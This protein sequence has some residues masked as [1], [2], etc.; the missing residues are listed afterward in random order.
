MTAAQLHKYQAETH[1]A[2][3][4][5]RGGGVLG[6]IAKHAPGFEMVSALGRKVQ[7][8]MDTATD[9]ANKAS[10]GLSTAKNITGG[11]LDKA[12]KF[13]ADA[14]NDLKDK[15]SGAW[16]R[17]QEL[18]SA[19]WDKTKEITGQLWESTKSGVGAAVE[20]TKNNWQYL[21]A[22]AVLAGGLLLG[23][24][25]SAGIVIGFAVSGGVEF[26]SQAIA[27][28][29][30]LSKIDYKKVANAS[31]VG[32]LAGGAGAGVGG[33]ITKSIATPALETASA[34][35]A[36]QTAAK[37]TAGKL[38]SGMFDSAVSNGVNGAGMEIFENGFKDPAA[39]AR[40]GAAG[41]ATGVLTPVGAAGTR[42][43]LNKAFGVTSEEVIANRV[44]TTV[45]DSLSGGVFGAGNYAISEDQS[46][47]TWEG[48]RDEFFK[49]AAS[50]GLTSD[51]VKSPVFE[52]PLQSGAQA[53]SPSQRD[54]I[55]GA[56][57]VAVSAN[58][59]AAEELSDDQQK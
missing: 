33:L 7:G 44:T 29:G 27:S 49:G 2:H 18:S 50:S 31:S 10:Q 9:F 1:A 40:K 30:D 42:L 26:G 38:A 12:K 23:G 53:V 39:I 55:S 58:G 28:K 19:A 20:W 14:L 59:V 57:G 32:G 25:I 46:K 37:G 52:Q 43:G 36:A 6:A 22:G 8:V 41:L 51:P 15:A 3:T 4:N 17:T 5:R 34:R 56:S 47:V 35:V 11:L 16:E 45:G 48:A 24:P 21:A 54:T 13:G